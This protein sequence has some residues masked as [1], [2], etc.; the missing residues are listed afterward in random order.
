MS[1]F[2]KEGHRDELFIIGKIWNDAHRPQLA[3]CAKMSNNP[4]LRTLTHSYA[5][6]YNDC[7]SSNLVTLCANSCVVGLPCCFLFSLLQTM[8][9]TTNGHQGAFGVDQT[10]I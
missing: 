1:D 10:S 6:A 8:P 5:G 7:M 2:I 3:R 9:K 4:K